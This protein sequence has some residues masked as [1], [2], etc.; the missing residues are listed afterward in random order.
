MLPKRNLKKPLNFFKHKLKQ[1]V[2]IFLA[3]E[4]KTI[5]KKEPFRKIQKYRNKF[6][7]QS[8]PPLS[9][10][11]LRWIMTSQSSHLHLHDVVLMSGYDLRLTLPSVSSSNS[12]IVSMTSAVQH[13][14]GIPLTTLLN[15][16]W[17]MAWFVITDV[18]VCK[19]SYILFNHIL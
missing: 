2:W 12:V 18:V 19:K 15:S 16:D 10:V 11:H 9:Y 13:G 7:R 5:Q 14:W 4:K 3:F 8:T 17:M 1:K 6:W